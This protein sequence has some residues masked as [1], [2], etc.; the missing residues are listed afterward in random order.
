MKK[1]TTYFTEIFIP[2][3]GCYNMT[4]QVAFFGKFLITFLT[5]KGLSFM[6]F[7]FVFF[8][9]SLG[10]KYFITYFTYVSNVVMFLLVLIE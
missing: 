6:Y 3:V 9:V 1:Y 7:L 8:E 10:V 4:F 2:L 5:F